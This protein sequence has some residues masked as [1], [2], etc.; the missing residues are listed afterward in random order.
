MPALLLLATLLRSDFRLRLFDF[1]LE[2]L[3]KESASARFV[4]P[5]KANEGH[6]KNHPALPGATRP[7]PHAHCQSCIGCSTPQ[8]HCWQRYS[9]TVVHAQTDPTFT[10]CYSLYNSQLDLATKGID[11]TSMMIHYPHSPPQWNTHLHTLLEPLNVVLLRV[12]LLIPK[13]LLFL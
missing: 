12:K 2:V 5:Q 8:G 9:S 4:S 13:L 3:P 7:R 10:Y 6:K 11:C 1:L